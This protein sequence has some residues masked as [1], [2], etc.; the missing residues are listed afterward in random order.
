MGGKDAVTVH[1]R[2]IR[3]DDVTVEPIA[4]PVLKGTGFFFAKGG[5]LPTNS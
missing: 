2:S 1:G 3:K 4:K 5:S